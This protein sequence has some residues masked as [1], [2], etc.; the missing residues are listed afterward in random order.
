MVITQ[1]AT[2]VIS[3][4]VAIV[5]P[6]LYF[7]I[8]HSRGNGQ[9]VGKRAGRIRVVARDGSAI[10]NRRTFWHRALMKQLSTFV[11]LLAAI[12]LFAVMIPLGLM[13]PTPTRPPAI[14]V[15]PVIGFV[16]AGLL[17]LL[18]TAYWLCD[19]LAVFFNAERRTL[20]DMLARTRVIWE[21]LDA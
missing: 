19:H 11:Y 5:L 6:L 4:G 16:I 3:F 12:V 8:Q 21:P 10:A 14:G 2:Q 1:V 15:L 7:A 17:Y 18:A 20:H 13:N 9:T